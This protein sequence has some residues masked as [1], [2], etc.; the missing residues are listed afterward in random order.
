MNSLSTLGNSRPT[1]VSGRCLNCSMTTTRGDHDSAPELAA[2]VLVFARDSRVAADRAEADVLLAAVTWAEQH[3]PESIHDAATWSTR[4][5][6]CPLPL[7][8]EGAPLVTEFCIAE[9]AAAI[10]RS[11]DSGR[12]QDC[13]GLELKYRLPRHWARVRSGTLEPWRA[14]RVAA[15]T[16]APEHGRRCLRGRAPWSRSHTRSAPPSSTG[17]SSRPPRGSCPNRRPRTRSGPPRNGTSPST[18][19]R[20]PRTAPRGCRPSSTWPMPSTSTPPSPPAPS[21][22]ASPGR[23][24]PSTYAA[25]SPPA[26]SPAASSAST[27]PPPRPFG[28]CRRTRQ[29]AKRPSGGPLRTPLRGSD[30]RQQLRTLQLAQV[31]NHRRTVLADQ[32]RAW[33]ATHETNVVVKPVIDLHEHLGVAGYEVPE[34]LAEQTEV[35]DGTCTFPG[36]PAP[37]SSA[38][39]N[40]SSPRHNGGRTCSCNIA[41]LCRRHHRLKTHTPWTYAVIDPG[42]YLWTE[43]PRLPVPPRPPR[44]HRRHPRPA[45]P[46]VHRPTRRLTLAHLRSHPVC[47]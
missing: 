4:G 40:T 23:P 39:P 30:H 18:T 42:T 44:H 7:A 38:T 21:S 29:K 43:P 2:D 34:R 35:R 25:P 41:P 14:C 17:S 33:C 16:L 15:A 37:P 31:G 45:T 32:V 24:S 5:G 8:G 19:T 1:S 46:G 10:G 47:G 12:P 9:F 6:D 36:A 26:R 13:H 27:S 20:F 3:P 11:T 22:S 28:R